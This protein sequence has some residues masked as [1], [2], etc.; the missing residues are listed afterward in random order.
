MFYFIYIPVYAGNVPVAF[1]VEDGQSSGVI[2]GMLK[3][4]GLIRS[5]LA[6]RTYVK[7]TGED[8]SLKA[9]RYN[10]SGR[11]DMS[12]I[13]FILVNGLS[14]SED[15][16]LLVSEGFNV[17][18]IDKR[19]VKLGLIKEGEFSSE[20]YKEEGYLFPDTYRIN[21]KSALPAEAGNSGFVVELRQ[22]M[23][24]NFENRTK[25]I[26]YG[27]KSEEQKEIII[28]ASILEKEA[29]TEADMR[30]VSGIIYNRLEKR[31]P[32]QID[33]TVTYG[34]CYRQFDSQVKDPGS[35]T[36]DC[37]VTFQ[38]VA[39]EIKIDGPYNS[40]T[41][42]GLPPGPISNPG[43]KAID[44]AMNPTKSNY[45]YYL[46]TRDGSR[47]IYSKTSTEHAANRLRYLGI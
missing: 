21:R 10:F 6:F 5:E 20:Y 38:G 27:L 34:A 46:S 42:N 14:E 33:A 36:Q 22:R 7:L 30:L 32:L 28:I 26:L 13:V 12:E 4:K 41:R 23:A 17:W 29:R 9:G 11:L 40:Y 43:L 25:Q 3:E 37:D 47:M 18:E 1:V 16:R 31:M 44:A 15:I 24:D 39:R 2:A 35:R 8:N 45:L 19:L